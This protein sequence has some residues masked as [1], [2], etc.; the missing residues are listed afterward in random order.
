M[1]LDQED[2]QAIFGPLPG[3]A[4]VTPPGASTWQQIARGGVSGLTFGLDKPL[5]LRPYEEA[6]PGGWPETAAWLTGMGVGFTPLTRAAGMGAAAATMLKP[7]FGALPK[8]LS[9]AGRLS[10]YALSGAAGAAVPELAEPEAHTLPGTLLSTALGA[11]LGAAGARI[12]GVKWRGPAGAL[13]E[14]AVDALSPS[15][16]IIGPTET[17]IPKSSSVA[18][19]ALETLR[20]EMSDVTSQIAKAPN[21]NIKRD[22][23]LYKRTLQRSIDYLERKA[24]L[25]PPIGPA[26]EEA[27]IAALRAISG[28]GPAVAED[29]DAL[30]QLGQSKALAEKMPL[31]FGAGESA[32]QQAGGVLEQS[33]ISRASGMSGN[34]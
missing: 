13:G 27:G 9:G 20:L 21:K 5:G 26:P 4:P 14:K 23:I 32:L 22:W 29:F 33:G 28:K 30:S 25:H 24:E 10:T 2:Y 8:A 12:A 19:E 3:Q 16:G 34:A 6:G 11:G 31:P 17:L 18:K 15:P 7:G 1:L